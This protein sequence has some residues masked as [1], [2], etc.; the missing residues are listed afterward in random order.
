MA[1]VVGVASAALL[2]IGGAA[3]AQDSSYRQ[4]APYYET[5]PFTADGTVIVN[6]EI[7][8]R[9]P[10]QRIRSSLLRENGGLHGD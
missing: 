6:G 10:D 1:A 7:V 8:G 2:A 4:A 3:T 5:G 9:D